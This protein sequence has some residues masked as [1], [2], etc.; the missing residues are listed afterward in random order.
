ML[1]RVVAGT[2]PGRL[3][4][5]STNNCVFLLYTSWSNQDSE[6]NSW[7]WC[8]AEARVNSAPRL[9]FFWRKKTGL[10]SFRN[11][12]RKNGFVARVATRRGLFQRRHKG[13]YLRPE[14]L[15]ERVE[16]VTALR[17]FR[18]DIG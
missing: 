16:E 18:P 10:A 9:C 4:F 13:V 6:Q 5:R 1:H 17:P 15:T 11:R 7:R 12:R 8:P 2:A 14:S 3:F